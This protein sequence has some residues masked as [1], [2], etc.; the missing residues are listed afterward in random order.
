MKLARQALIIGLALGILT[1]VAFPKE[2][3]VIMILATVMLSV[4][5]LLAMVA[6]KRE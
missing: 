4:L 3:K 5:S 2:D 6:S 1:L